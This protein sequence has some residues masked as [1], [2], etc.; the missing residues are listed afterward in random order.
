LRNQSIRAA[1]S[2]AA[3]LAEGCGRP[4]R[5][6]FLHFVGIAIGSVNELES[7]LGTATRTRILSAHANAALAQRLNLVRRMLIAMMRALER[8]I[9]EDE[10][11]S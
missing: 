9:A 3:N 1:G 10:N 4:S 2:V 8:Q 7:H 11:R 5:S 6:E